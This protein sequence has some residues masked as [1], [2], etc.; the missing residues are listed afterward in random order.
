M[1][2]PEDLLLGE[3]AMKHLIQA[4]SRVQ[5]GSEGLF[6]HQASPPGAQGEPGLGQSLDGGREGRWRDGQV[7]DPVAG[8]SVAIFD[9]CY[10]FCQGLE[11]VS[12]RLKANAVVTPP[13]GFFLAPPALDKSV[14]H[15]QTE[16]VIREVRRCHTQKVHAVVEVTGLQQPIDRRNQ[17]AAGKV[18]CRSEQHHQVRVKANGLGSRTGCHSNKSVRSATTE[19]GSDPRWILMTRLPDSTS[20]W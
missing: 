12:D 20:A 8:Q 19:S 6:D 1:V 15:Y 5:I 13:A 11:A 7:E 3:M 18:P 16:I 2:D 10:P 17:H 9:P 14:A 4:T